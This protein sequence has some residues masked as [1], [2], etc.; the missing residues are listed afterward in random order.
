VNTHENERSLELEPNAPVAVHS[1]MVDPERKLPPELGARLSRL[2]PGD[3]HALVAL[4]REFPDFDDAILTQAAAIVGN[5][6]TGQ[7]I[8]LLVAGNAAESEAA[9]PTRGRPPVQDYSVAGF[10][11]EESVLTLEGGD[12]VGDHL[13]FIAM[14]PELRNKVIDGLGQANPSLV[15]DLLAR[16]AAEETAQDQAELR[17][18]TEREA[19]GAAKDGDSEVETAPREE[20]KEASWVTGAKRYNA[21]H[22][23][24]VAE[25]NRVTRDACVGV[26]GVVDPALVSDWQAAH[27][28][29]PDGRIGEFTVEAA[30]RAAGIGR[31]VPM[32]EGDLGLE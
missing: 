32:P 2:Q 1:E 5:Q 8:E 23:E 11:Y 25:F 4:V 28:L 9:T 10:R 31:P 16:L 17:E 6:T 24:E 13:K 21:A 30:R 20:A 19:E 15:D 12:V 22:P 26:D 27:G 14:Y 18:Q 3:A 7:A 29:S